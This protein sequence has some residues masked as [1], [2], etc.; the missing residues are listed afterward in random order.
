M[1]GGLMQDTVNG[2]IR[3]RKWPRPR[4]KAKTT[5]EKERQDKFRTV[6][7]AEKFADPQTQE[8]LIRAT[9]DT[10]LYPRDIWTSW[11]YGTFARFMLPDGRKVYPVATR[12]SVSDA[13]DSITQKEGET[14]VRGKEFWEGGTPSGGSALGLLM[15]EPILAPQSEVIS[16]PLGTSNLLAIFLNEITADGSS[17]RTIELSDDNGLNWFTASGDY[18][19]AG[20]TGASG[21]RDGIE[22]Q[23]SQSTSIRSGMIILLGANSDSTPFWTLPQ[24]REMGFLNAVS[25]PVNRFR[26]VTRDSGGTYHNMTGGRVTAWAL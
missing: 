13:L 25:G 12:N 22:T 16:P 20:S 15:D 4:G 21:N 2:E 18:R 10:P 26:V 1:R 14:L 5:A 23:S 17:L 6:Q 9:K 24:R 19:I 7:F 11:M 3:S 8:M